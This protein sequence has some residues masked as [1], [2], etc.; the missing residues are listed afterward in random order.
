MK[1][2]IL[3]VS[4]AFV[5]FCKEFNLPRLEAFHLLNLK[6]CDMYGELQCN[7]IECYM[8]TL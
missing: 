4:L 5:I 3:L 2:D 1:I 7:V 8:D 6:W